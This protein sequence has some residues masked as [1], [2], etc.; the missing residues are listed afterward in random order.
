[1]EHL[2]FAKLSSVPLRSQQHT[3]ADVPAVAA[4]PIPYN[5]DIASVVDMPEVASLDLDSG[6][7]E[8]VADEDMLEVNV[9]DVERNADFGNSKRW[10]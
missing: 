1:M 5:H 3:H 2:G 8:L 9:I 6:S 10:T 7:E 4:N